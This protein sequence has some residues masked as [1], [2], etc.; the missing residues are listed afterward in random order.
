MTK[1]AFLIRQSSVY[2]GT[3][4]WNYQRVRDYGTGVSKYQNPRSS[5]VREKKN[6]NQGLPFVPMDYP[7]SLF[8]AFNP[9]GWCKEHYQGIRIASIVCF[10]IVFNSLVN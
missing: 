3:N 7:S 10:P 4:G 2:N 8:A 1:K 9:T 6:R 5:V